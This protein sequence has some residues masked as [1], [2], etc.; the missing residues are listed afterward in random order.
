[1]EDPVLFHGLAVGRLV[2]GVRA[3]QREQR[4][5][6]VKLG[7][8]FLAG[9]L[10]FGLGRGAGRA[11]LREGA[12]QRAFGVLVVPEDVRE[13]QAEGVFEAESVAVVAALADNFGFGDVQRCR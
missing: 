9:G 2:R 8:H 4:V 5:L 10:K 7:Q 11:E 13:G 3:D 6:A 1:M 12:G